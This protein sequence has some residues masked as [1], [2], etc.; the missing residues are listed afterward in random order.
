M[1]VRIST[2]SLG[3]I[4]DVR[5]QADYQLMDPN[6]VGLIFSCFNEAEKVAC[7]IFFGLCNFSYHS[8]SATCKLFASS[9]FLQVTKGES[10][11][12]T[13]LTLT[14]ILL[15]FSLEHV[16]L[17]LSMCPTVAGTIGPMTLTALTRLPH[18]LVEEEKEAYALAHEYATTHHLSLQLEMT[19]FLLLETQQIC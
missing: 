10:D 1:C 18:I 7:A 9:Q 19:C 16:E 3:T 17:P 14:I 13:R 6:F 8:R 5:T 11:H 15:L 4:A 12:T 2:W